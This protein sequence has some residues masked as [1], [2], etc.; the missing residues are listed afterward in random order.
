MGGQGGRSES[1]E[2]GGRAMSACKPTRWPLHAGIFVLKAMSG[3]KTGRS[4]T[5]VERER[6]VFLHDSGSSYCFTSQLKQEVFLYFMLFLFHCLSALFARA[7][8][9]VLQTKSNLIISYF[10]F[11]NGQPNRRLYLWPKQAQICF[12]LCLNINRST[13]NM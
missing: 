8:V 6:E 2:P 5:N 1:V 4:C 12:V 7:F 11:C 10:A 13:E 9:A 3:D